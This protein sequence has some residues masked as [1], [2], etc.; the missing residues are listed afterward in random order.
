MAPYPQPPTGN[1]IYKWIKKNFHVTFTWDI[2][3]GGKDEKIAQMTESGNYPDLLHIDSRKFYDAGALIPLDELIEK[4]APRLKEHY[5]GIWERMKEDDGHVYTLPAWGV[6]QGRDWSS[7]YGDSAMWVQKDVLREAGY[8]KITTMD[9][10]FN[11]L[12][13]YKRKHPVI[14]GQSTI[15]FTILTADW[16][17][18][19]M[20]NPP[21]FLAGFPNDGNGT[22]DP[23]THEYKSILYQD[24]SK[25]WFRKLNEL[26]A[27]GV[28]DRSCFTD[29]YEQYLEKIASGRV[30]GFHDQ[31]WQFQQ[32]ENS[33]VSQDMYN[34]TYAPLPI[35]FDASVRPHYRNRKLPNIGMGLG[36]SVKAKDPVRII[37]FLDAELSDDAQKVIGFWGIK[38]QDY[39]FD[40]HGIPYRTDAQ[41]MQQRDD[42][43]KL[44]NQAQL[45]YYLSPKIEGSFSNGYPANINDIF[46]EKIVTMRD[47][48]R[49]LWDAYNVSSYPEMMDMDPPENSVWFPAWQIQI[50]DGSEAKLTWQRAEAVY[51]EY[52]P[53]IILAPA[54]QFEALW[55]EYI[56]ELGRTGLDK[57]EAYMQSEINK[58]IQLWTPKN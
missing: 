50:R 4:Y 37:R 58:R 35:V 48:D 8:P 6:T 57:Y 36:I 31:G 26:N 52:L 21:N 44:Q 39:Q 17:S 9:E 25:R 14:N 53:R 12:I 51:R 13:N 47:E 46:G 24:I 32:A 42:N 1:K 40:Q 2:M 33:L 43:W 30:L 11:L 19:C 41:R 3:E 54:A 29:T 34:R 5:A 18:F 45:W 27:L 20:I 16:H 28:I 10:Y 7:W 38:G 23:V 55:Q 22:V 49:K 56:G 15:A